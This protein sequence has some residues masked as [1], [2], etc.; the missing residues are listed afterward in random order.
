M[1]LEHFLPWREEPRDAL[2]LDKSYWPMKQAPQKAPKH[3]VIP[4]EARNLSFFSWAQ[5]RERFLAS[6]GMTKLSTF[7]VASKVCPSE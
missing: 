5:T 6:L 2:P 4:S 3:F 1:N 7:S